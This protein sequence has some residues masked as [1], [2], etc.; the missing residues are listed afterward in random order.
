VN[1]AILINGLINRYLESSLTHYSLLSILVVV[2]F[3][4][5][6]ILALQILKKNLL[7][8]SETKPLIKKARNGFAIYVVYSI[9]LKLIGYL[10]N[11]GTLFLLAL[12]IL[13]LINFILVLIVEF[14][15]IKVFSILKGKIV[16]III[17]PI[18]S[19]SGFMFFVFMF[20]LP[21]IVF[22]YSDKIQGDQGTLIFSSLLI[23][24]YLVVFLPIIF[25][26]IK[27]IFINYKKKWD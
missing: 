2:F 12:V 4:I 8:Y 7:I 19:L 27:K 26:I 15:I 21:F 10:R 5:I 22:N 9:I 16:G 6:F 24:I 20:W 23:G 17:I 3:I 13:I 25:S 18:V 11:D 1:P 14:I